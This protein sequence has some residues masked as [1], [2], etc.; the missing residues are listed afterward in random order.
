MANVEVI[1]VESSST[2]KKFIN[3]PNQ[4]YKGDKNYVPHLFV[5]RKEFFNFKKN[6]FYKSA[7]VKLFL[8]MLDNE[9]V[10]RIAT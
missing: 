9:V 5:E 1:E 10:W 4:L 3:Y 2:L 6:P 7:S 8:A